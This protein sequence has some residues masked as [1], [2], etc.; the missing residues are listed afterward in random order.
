MGEQEKIIVFREFENPID[1]SIIKAKLDAHGIPCFLTGENL[2]N[3][4]PLPN[5]A[6]LHV[7]LYLFEKDAD[8]AKE[9]LNEN[10]SFQN[11]G[12]RINEL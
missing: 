4:Y 5:L 8:L 3:M 7:R 11:P 2:A 1:A 10:N 9:V 6:S 12:M